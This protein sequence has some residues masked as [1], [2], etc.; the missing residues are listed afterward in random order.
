M[1]QDADLNVLPV[2][3]APAAPPVSAPA[4]PAPAPAQEPQRTIDPA[5]VANLENYV[6]QQQQELQRLEPIKDD[7]AW[8]LE[9]ESRREGIRKYRE[10]YESAAKPQRPPELEALYT[11][12]DQS[13]APVRAYITKQEQA[14]QRV[15]QESRQKFTNENMAF[16]ARLQAKEKLTQDELLDVGAYADALAMRL[17]R[18]VGIEEAWK[19][20]SAR[21]GVAAP[22]AADAPVLR[23]DAGAIGVPGASTDPDKNK[24]YLTDFHGAVAE[25]IRNAQRAS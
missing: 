20:M 18:D 14:E 16:A 12:I 4:A 9:D 7:V 6:R 2:A 25:S 8:M 3:P 22:D 1:H 11:H 24:R 5:Y 21:R 19:K 13:V 17:Q 10:A 23:G 15:A